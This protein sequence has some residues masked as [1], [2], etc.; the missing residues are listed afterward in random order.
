MKR[1]TLNLLVKF[2]NSQQNIFIGNKLESDITELLLSRGYDKILLL[3]DHNVYTTFFKPIN[4][5]QKRLD[6]PLVSLNIKDYK[7]YQKAH[8]LINKIFNF[9][10][11]RKSCLLVI[12]GGSLGDLAG[13][14][15][16]IYMRGISMAYLPTTFMSQADSIIG[17]VA[18]NVGKEKNLVGSFFSP[19]YTFCDLQYLKKSRPQQ[20]LHGLVEIWKHAIIK[21]NKKI[22]QSIGKS[23]VDK[24][25]T[26]RS[27]IYQSLKIKAYFVQKDPYDLKG[28][29]KSLSLGHTTANFLEKDRE[30]NHGEAVLYGIIL[31]TFISKEMNILKVVNFTSLVKSFNGFRRHMNKDED[32]ITALNFTNFSKHLNRDK[33]NSHGQY[34]FVVPTDKGYKV[35]KITNKQIILKAIKKLKIF[36]RTKNLSYES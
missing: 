21:N 25:T 9:G 20:H 19:T 7:D 10:L 36:L 28:I 18:V 11:T 27:L 15:S 29:H 14:V 17:K 34:S 32:F 31:A 30:F 26:P 6:A 1:K 23:I 22:T 5:L 13:F 24:N 35:V 33:I 12:G 2:P 4:F 3:V 16:S 8:S